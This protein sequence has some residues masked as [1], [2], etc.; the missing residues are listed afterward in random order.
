MPRCAL[1]LGLVLLFPTLGASDCVGK[2]KVKI[3]PDVDRLDPATNTWSAQ[4]AIPTNRTVEGAT[5]VNDRIYVLGGFR[6]LRGGNLSDGAEV[7]D[8]AAGS[9]SRLA[10]LPLPRAAR[11]VA[12]AGRIHLVGGWSRPPGQPLQQTLRHDIYDP[13]TDTWSLGADLPQVGFYGTPVVANGRLRVIGSY[14]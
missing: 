3:V 12:V 8:P 9:W 2:T 4:P 10:D 6:T 14:G 13:G 5:V 7:F 1:L 11:A